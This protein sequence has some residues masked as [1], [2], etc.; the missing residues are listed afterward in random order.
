MKVNSYIKVNH[1]HLQRVLEARRAMEDRICSENVKVVS[2]FR[3][4]N[5]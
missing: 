3:R 5:K 1:K 2:T 4:T